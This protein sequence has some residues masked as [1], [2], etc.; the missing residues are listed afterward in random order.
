MRKPTSDALVFNMKGAPGKKVEGI[1]PTRNT[2]KVQRV[3]RGTNCP[4]GNRRKTS[5][6]KAR[7]RKYSVSH[8][9][10]ASRSQR[11]CK[12]AELCRSRLSVLAVGACSTFIG[13]LPVCCP[14]PVVDGS[15]DAHE[16]PGAFFLQISCS[17]KGIFI[18]SHIT[19]TT[20][21]QS[22]RK[23]LLNATSLWP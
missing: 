11:P 3:Q 5:T 22:L 8:T 23:R 13:A 12:R 6:S 9:P 2:T 20:F 10:R 16:T 1:C 4:L 7:V 15:A 21:L 14:G 17:K 18:L 19:T